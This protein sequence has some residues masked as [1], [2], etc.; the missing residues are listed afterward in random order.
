MLSRVRLPVYRDQRRAYS[1]SST[2]ESSHIKHLSTSSHVGRSKSAGERL[3]YELE[4]F[5][6]RAKTELGITTPNDWYSVSRSDIARIGGT[7]DRYS[8]FLFALILETSHFP[9]CRPVPS[10]TPFSIFHQTLRKCISNS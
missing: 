7:I 4:A 6:L 2:I 3:Q 9:I 5:L 10:K 8:T 1:T